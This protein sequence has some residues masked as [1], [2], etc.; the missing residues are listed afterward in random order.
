M[1]R[2]NQI[3]NH[4][5]YAAEYQAL[6]E[7]ERNRIYCKHGVDHLLEVARLCY[8]YCLEEGVDIDRELVYAAALL[9]DIGRHQ[10]NATGEPHDQAGA[11]LAKE[12]MA[13]CGFSEHEIAMVVDAIGAHRGPMGSDPGTEFSTLLRKADKKSRLCFICEARDTCNWPD[14]KKN[15]GIEL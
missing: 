12:I 5:V 13:E 8:L 9:H 2:L 11:R 3:Y 1:D 10:Q 4:P 6:V 15:M 7:D 14:E